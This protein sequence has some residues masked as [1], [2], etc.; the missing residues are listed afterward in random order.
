MEPSDLNST[1]QLIREGFLYEAFIR[2]LLFL[3]TIQN[4]RLLL[5]QLPI[6]ER[7]ELALH[8]ERTRQY[9]KKIKFG[10]RG[11]F[12]PFVIQLHQLRVRLKRFEM[13]IKN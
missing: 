10:K 2:D 4:N 8:L 3:N 13:V 1:E 11:R 9:L 6:E 12:K 5:Q 7:Q